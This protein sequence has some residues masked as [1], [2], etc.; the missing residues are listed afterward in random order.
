MLLST[1]LLFSAWLP[2][3]PSV[4]VTTKYGK[5]EGLTVSYPNAPGSFEFNSISKFLGVPFAAPPT[6]ERRL[7]AP[8]PPNKWKPDVRLAKKHADAC[9]QPRRYESYFNRYDYN[10]SFSEDCLYLDVY[11]PDITVSS[12]VLVYIHGGAYEGGT[13]IAFPSD[14]LALHGVIVVVIQ[15][16]LGPFGFLTTGDSAAPGNFGML[17]QVEALK[18][19]RDN[20][21]NFGGNPSKVTIFGESAGGSS[22]S[23][24]LM[25]PLSEG[26]FHQVIAE[27][28]VDLCPWAVQPVSYGLRFAKELTQKLEC[29]LSD[30][31]A[32]I[33]CIRKAK[34][35]DIQKASDDISF[36]FYDYFRWAPVVDQNFLQD[37]P[38]NLRKKGAFKKLPLMVS[39]N[40]H[41]GAT[42]ISLIA[43]GLFGKM[44]KSVDN[45]VDPSYFKD[46]LIKL[47]HARNSRCVA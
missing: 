9:M 18:W 20:I 40:S 42:F 30:H 45:G 8:Q 35:V 11:T 29:T 34:D 39:F 24:H 33:D 12:P 6:G 38:K 37:T 5:L 19:V 47:P 16:R 7:R 17:D 10:I 2:L 44:A 14:I 41:E 15:Y 31:N 28:G 26:L 25:S 23:L 43:K 3:V 1:L 46:F 22:V 4:T 27:S 36:E 13:S 21:E 32:M